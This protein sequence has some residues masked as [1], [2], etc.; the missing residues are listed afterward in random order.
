M[1]IGKYMSNTKLILDTSTEK[2]YIN[3]DS[4]FLEEK[5]IILIGKL[6]YLQIHNSKRNGWCQQR[7]P[8][9]KYRYEFLL[10]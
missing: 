3:D 4:R 8:E 10:I 5:V 9:L 7:I 6:F 2:K 1:Q